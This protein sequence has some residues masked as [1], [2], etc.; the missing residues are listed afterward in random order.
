M[1]TPKTR[2]SKNNLL[3]FYQ[4]GIILQFN[5]VICNRIKHHYSLL[6]A[7][8]AIVHISKMHVE[9]CIVMTYNIHIIPA[10]HM[11]HNVAK[12]SIVEHLNAVL[13]A[14]HIIQIYPT[15]LNAAPA[16]NAASSPGTITL[17]ILAFET[18]TLPRT[19]VT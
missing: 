9:Q 17:L 19:S 5:F 18:L 11:H 8:S 16:S 4:N 1:G 10:A 14:S 2:K 3:L 12:R 6:D 15:H 7:L 13:P